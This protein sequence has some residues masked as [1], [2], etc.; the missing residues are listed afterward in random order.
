L[1]VALALAAVLYGVVD[2]KRTLASLTQTANAQA[3]LPVQIILPTPGPKHGPLCYRARC[4]HGTR[5][6][7]F[8]QVSGYVLSWNVDYGA[9]VRAGQ[10]L[11]T[12]D[13]P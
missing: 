11:A 6:S 13:T 9:P 3:A 5:P 12:I 1:A 10:L 7:I 4:A 2:R 8:A